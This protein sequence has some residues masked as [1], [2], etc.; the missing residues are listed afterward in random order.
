LFALLLFLFSFLFHLFGS[1]F[2]VFFGALNFTRDICCG[3]G[4]SACGIS[5]QR[6]GFCSSCEGNGCGF[7]GQWG[8]N[9]LGLCQV[10]AC[11]IITGMSTNDIEA[12]F[13][14]KGGKGGIHAKTFDN[15]FKVLLML[16][17]ISFE[18]DFFNITHINGFVHGKREKV[19]EDFDLI[20]SD[21]DRCVLIKYSFE[22]H[23][24]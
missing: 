7:S 3:F 9:S 14:I 16:V 23:G 10:F 5:S 19:F 18:I 15:N 13:G 20:R 4:S 24:G 6:N 2:D 17:D 12:F 1:L 11:K 21:S 8:G 22:T